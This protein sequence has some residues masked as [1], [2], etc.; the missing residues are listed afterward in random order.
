M[1][2]VNA[3]NRNVVLLVHVHAMVT[4]AGLD[5]RGRISGIGIAGAV[6]VK[7]TTA[8]EPV[9]LSGTG[10][11]RSLLLAA[12]SIVEDVQR[13]SRETRT[14]DIAGIVAPGDYEIG[15]RDDW[16][17]TCAIGAYGYLIAA[18]SA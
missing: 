13:I 16:P 18:R 10:N 8:V 9:T 2:Y 17:R 1:L 5:T 6:Q 4:H 12:R 15:R 11:R 7:I 14:P 3:G